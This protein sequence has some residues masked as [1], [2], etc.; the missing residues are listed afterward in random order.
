MSERSRLS[1]ITTLFGARNPTLVDYERFVLKN[2][3]TD[4]EEYFTSR[5]NDQIVF[6]LQAVLVWCASTLITP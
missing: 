1:R 4:G 3:L 6:F 2:F 5:Q